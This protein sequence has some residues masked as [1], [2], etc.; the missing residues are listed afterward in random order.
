[1]TGS[2]SGDDALRR[3]ARNA[4]MATE[5]LDARRL[6]RVLRQTCRSAPGRGRTRVAVQRAGSGSIDEMHAI[7]GGAPQHHVCLIAAGRVVRKPGLD[8]LT[9]H[10]AS[11]DNADHIEF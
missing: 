11:V 3:L 10:R 8:L 9:R 4:G 5:Q 2:G 7:A 6:S 1:M